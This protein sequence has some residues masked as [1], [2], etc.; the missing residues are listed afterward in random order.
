MEPKP[1]LKSYTMM[2]RWVSVSCSHKMGTSSSRIRNDAKNMCTIMLLNCIIM[3]LKIVICRSLKIV[4]FF[5]KYMYLPIKK[6]LN[7]Y[8]AITPYSNGCCKNDL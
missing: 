3:G 6:V 7:T 8:M 5:I 2:G 1:N 4:K